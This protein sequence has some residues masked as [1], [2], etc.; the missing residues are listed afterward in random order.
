MLASKIY[1]SYVL[2][3][4][5][6]EVKLR[7]NQYGGVRGLG[8]DH[9]FVQIWQAM[10]QIAEDYRA[11]AV[12]T[13]IDYSKAFNRMSFKECLKSLAKKQIRQTSPCGSLLPSLLAG[14]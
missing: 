4:L 8:T 14:G 10:L 1:E 11:A 12:V 13:S 7:T 3:W 5:K 2:D 9:L 6:L